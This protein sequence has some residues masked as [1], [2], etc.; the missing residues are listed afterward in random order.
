METNLLELI[1][2]T[3]CAFRDKWLLGNKKDSQKSQRQELVDEIYKH[4]EMSQIKYTTDESLLFPTNYYII[5]QSEED[6]RFHHMAFYDSAHDALKKISRQIKNKVKQYPDYVAHSRHFFFTFVHIGKDDKIDEKLLQ[7]IFETGDAVNEKA[8]RILS[9]IYAP[10]DGNKTD[11]GE[12]PVAMTVHSKETVSFK[13]LDI[14]I[15]AL[16]NVVTRGDNLFI[17]NFSLDGATT[18]TTEPTALPT[19]PVA[20]LKAQNSC[21]IINGETRRTYEMRTDRLHVSGRVGSPNNEGKE[22]ARI[23]NDQVLNPHLIIRKTPQGTFEIKTKGDTVLN[24]SVIDPFLNSWTPLPNN[25][26]ILINGDIQ[27]RFMAPRTQTPK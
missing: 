19:E 16:S 4:F 18:A 22:I 21:F 10:S 6:Y 2:E 23:N 17:F 15:A 20:T 24:E 11:D 9:T 27:L 8:T 3:W 13:E 25:S 26:R 14:N 5:I 1:K 12:A 7:Q